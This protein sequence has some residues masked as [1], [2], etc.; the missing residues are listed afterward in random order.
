MMKAKTK[1]IL[2]S[3]SP[4]RQELLRNITDNFQ[5]IVSDVEEN[6][7]KSLPDQVVMEL[8]SIK[9]KAVFDI[10]I[11][12]DVFQNYDQA[13]VIGADTIVAYNGEILG[14]PEDEEDAKNMLLLLSDRTHQVY[15]GVS[16][17]LFQNNEIKTL[18][19]CEST[20]VTFLPLD[21][22]E[23]D[24][25]VKTKDPMD[26]AGSYGIQGVFSKHIKA[27][28]GDYYNVM[29]LPVSRLYTELKN[30]RIL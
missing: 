8:S 22:F 4:R 2:A 9:A 24:D 6:T 3:G 27:I 20:D 26:K 7:E 15:T 16:L 30:L 17:Y 14:K 5:V 25:Y 12:D 19:F 13:V 23:I 10:C 28:K 18:S 1:F 21:R 11:K 29:G